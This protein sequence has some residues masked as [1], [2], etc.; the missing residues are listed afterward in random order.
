MVLPIASVCSTRPPVSV[1]V[2]APA[3]LPRSFSREHG[4][5]GF[6]QSLR[7]RASPSCRADLPTLRAAR[8]HGDVQ[9]PAR[10]SFSVAPSVMT[11]SRWCRNVCLLCIGYAF[12]PRLS[13]RL[14]LGGLALPRK[15]WTC[16]GG[17]FHASLVTHASIRTPGRSTVGCPPASLR[18]GRSPTTE[19]IS[20]PLRYHA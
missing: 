9:N 7:R 17:V 2:R 1:L 11:S 20:P 15:P 3:A 16:G 5:T 19:E 10:L 14:T 12:R 13:S 8:F 18:T 4:I 6:T